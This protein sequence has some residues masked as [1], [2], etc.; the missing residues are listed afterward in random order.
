VNL[1]LVLPEIRLQIAL[2]LEM[3]QL[4]LDDRDALGK[5]AADIADPHV[6]TR[7]DATLAM[8]FDHHTH[9]LFYNR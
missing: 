9:L 3:I 5:V 4:Q 2:D 1:R 6:Q 8:C 7:H